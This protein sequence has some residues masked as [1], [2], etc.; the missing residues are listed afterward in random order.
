MERPKENPAGCRLNGSNERPTGKA[1]RKKGSFMIPTI[2]LMIGGYIFLRCLEI[3]ATSDR[4]ESK[5]NRVIV[6]I[7]AFAVLILAAIGS[8]SLVQSSF[9]AQTKMEQLGFPFQ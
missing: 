5:S 9:N 1:R 6:G 4:I 7:F 2:G 8:V 3:F